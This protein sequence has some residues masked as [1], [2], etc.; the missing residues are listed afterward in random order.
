MRAHKRESERSRVDISPRSLTI[1][2]DLIERGFFESPRELIEAALPL[3]QVALVNETQ[4]FAE[5]YEDA[6]SVME[7]SDLQLAER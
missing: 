6:E 4:H 1:I 3:L 7:M 5:Q 2:E